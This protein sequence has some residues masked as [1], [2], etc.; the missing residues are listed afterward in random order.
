MAN[1]RIE[2]IFKEC[3]CRRTDFIFQNVSKRMPIC[4][5]HRTRL[6]NKIRWCSICD[7]ETLCSNYSNSKKFVCPD[8]RRANNLEVK[9]LRALKKKGSRTDIGFR[10]N[11]GLKHRPEAE[12]PLFERI[13]NK[14]FPKL[15]MPK[16]SHDMLRI[17]NDHLRKSQRKA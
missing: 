10:A 16:L 6:A 11:T 13:L 4:P 2:Y 12:I 7:T 15:K 14:K 9:R 5:E 3:G 17:Y 1:D 8:C